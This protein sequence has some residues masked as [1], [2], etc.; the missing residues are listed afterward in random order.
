MQVPS[1]TLDVY[2]CTVQNYHYSDTAFWDMLSYSLI[3]GYMSTVWR[4]LLPPSSGQKYEP[5]RE[6][7]VHDMGGAHQYQDYDKTT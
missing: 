1:E 5:S 3:K 7:V 4:N 6:E 2:C